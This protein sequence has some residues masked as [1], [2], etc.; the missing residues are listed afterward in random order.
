MPR[1]E[2]DVVI[3]IP[4]YNCAATIVETIRSI[5]L[6]LA[7]R[8]D[9]LIIDNNSTDQTAEFVISARNKGLLPRSLQLIRTSKNVGYAGSQKLAFS[10]VRRSAAVRWVIMLHGDGQYPSELLSK[11]VPLMESE[12]SLVYGYRSKLS[13]WRLE[14]TPFPTWAVIKLLGALETAVTGYVRKEWHSGFN[15]YSVEFLRKLPLS[16]MTDTSHI[17]GQISFLAGALG[18]PVHAIPIYKRYKGFNSFGGVGR[19]KY[20][21]HVLRLMFEFRLKRRSLLE[22]PREHSDFLAEYVLLSRDIK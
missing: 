19:V 20:V 17:D 12:F 1:F 4:A 15:M 9:V 13:Y 8:A 3:Y 11:F 21:F 10:L 6:D 14:G 2:R 7:A 18:E 22:R 16:E 5:P